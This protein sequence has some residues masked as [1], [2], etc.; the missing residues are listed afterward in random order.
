MDRAERVPDVGE[1]VAEDEA[2]GVDEDAWPDDRPVAI[3]DAGHRQV[4]EPGPAEDGLDVDRAGEDVSQHQAEEG[5]HRDKG[6]LQ[7]DA[8]A[9]HAVLDA[10]RP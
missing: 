7:H 8:V 2:D 6:V 5:H 3:A 4:A 9:D 1:K 10:V